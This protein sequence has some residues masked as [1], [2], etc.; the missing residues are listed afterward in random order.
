M[1]KSTAGS[2][3]A[4]QARIK[5]NVIWRKHGFTDKPPLAVQ[6]MAREL[7]D[8]LNIPVVIGKKLAQCVIDFDA[9]VQISE[10]DKKRVFK[11]YKPLPKQQ[12]NPTKDAKTDFYA[13][14][15]WRTLRMEVLKEFGAV[16]MCCGSTPQHKDM[17]GNQV[18]I[19]VDHIK[20]LH[21]HWSLRLQKTNLQVLCDECNQGK[22][23]WDE[24]DHRPKPAPDEWT[25]EDEPSDLIAD[26]LKIRH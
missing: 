22:G 20:P 8:R 14:W 10:A 17:S 3:K 26:Q 15:D 16:C 19:V 21:H 4:K 5:M 2:R 18:K 6:K 23:A 25:I 9:G 11:A 13:S 24:T 1:S 7:C 12:K